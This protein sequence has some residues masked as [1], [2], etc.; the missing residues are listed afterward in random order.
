MLSRV[1]DQDRAV[2]QFVRVH[3]TYLSGLSAPG[4]PMQ[5]LLFVGPTGSGKTLVAETFAD[6]VNV[7][8]IKVDCAEFQ[9]DHEV[10]K[11]IGA[12]PGY[13]GGNIEPKISKR[14]IEQKWDKGGPKYTVILFDEIE[15]ADPAFHQLLLGILDKGTLTSGR[16]ELIDLSRTVIVMTSNLGSGEVKK[17]LT[18][19]GYGFTNA[20]KEKSDLDDKI[21]RASKGA[22]SR[23]FSPEFYN[24]LDR[25]VVF[26]PLTDSGLRKILDIELGLVQDRLL[27]ADKFIGI[28]ISDSA[29]NFLFAEGTSPELGARELKRTI[30]RFVVSKISRAIA[31]D[32][33]SSSDIILVDMEEDKLSFQIMKKV[34]V[35]PASKQ[36]HVVKQP[37]AAKVDPERPDAICQFESVR[38][39]GYCGRCGFGW[40][41]RHL[42]FDLLDDPKP[43]G[44]KDAR[45]ETYKFSTGVSKYKPLYVKCPICKSKWIKNNVN[46]C[47]DC[48]RR[49]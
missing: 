49:A 23:F 3:E 1:I 19:S 24:R 11:L 38:N 10:A 48:L 20:N 27:K 4:R 13:V 21:Y 16:N 9:H 5:I 46:M 36:V 47:D 31:S 7:G 30:E 12:P 41:E 32:Q 8:F 34:L 28:E 18:E 44:P 45:W 25:M 2:K 6:A 22:V 37:R 17:L 42:C 33:A 26:R 43:V 29:K 35:V 15:K 14:I 40:S 39:P